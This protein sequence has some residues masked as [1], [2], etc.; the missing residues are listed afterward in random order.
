[1]YGVASGKGGR[2][3]D[4]FPT[5][6][7]E[8]SSPHLPRTILESPFPSTHLPQTCLTSSTHGESRLLQIPTRYSS[9][10]T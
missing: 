9:D 1:M 10:W 6:F 4:F 8:A 2:W 3:A 5:W 7:F